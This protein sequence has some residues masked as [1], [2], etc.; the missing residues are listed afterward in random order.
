MAALLM[1]IF[2]GLFSF[3]LMDKTVLLVR[4]CVLNNNFSAGLRAVSGIIIAQLLWA[5]LAALA[6][7]AI[8]YELV[9]G[10]HINSMHGLDT[11]FVMLGAL[12]LGFVAYR[13][14]QRPLPM[15]NNDEAIMPGHEW[16]SLLRTALADPLRILIYLA[17]FSLLGLHFIADRIANFVFIVL[18]TGF[19]AFVAWSLFC[20]IIEQQKEKIT[21][22]QMQRFS[23]WGAGLILLLVAFS[24]V[25]VAFH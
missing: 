19:G 3:L 13:L 2:A 1:G 12:I 6:I 7:G 18:G 23:R 11:S 16:Q 10:K 22:E 15:V 9:I 17:L 4:Q 25:L 24:L 8:R 5:L 14:I 21:L 20:S